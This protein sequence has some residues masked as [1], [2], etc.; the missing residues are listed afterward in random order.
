MESPRKL[1]STQINVS[2]APRANCHFNF[3]FSRNID[4]PITVL[5]MLKAFNV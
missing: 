4:Y 2:I 3:F 5:R 1:T